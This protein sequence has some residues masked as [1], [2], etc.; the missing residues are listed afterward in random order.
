ME[1]DM[2]DRG[3]GVFLST[4]RRHELLAGYPL[5]SV[6]VLKTGSIQKPK[7]LTGLIRH[8]L[9]KTAHWR[10]RLAEAAEE[11]GCDPTFVLTRETD[12]SDLAEGLYIKWEVDGVVKERYKWV[13]S[14]FI[15]AI[16]DSGTHW[17][18]RPLI[19]NQLA[20][21]VDLYAM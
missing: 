15:Q 1:F 3:T 16:L 2:Y 20:E 10:E 6:P 8:S 12:N 18:K 4:E 7:D 11:A 19:P 21:D 9:Y 14:N 13:R 5:V 17:Q